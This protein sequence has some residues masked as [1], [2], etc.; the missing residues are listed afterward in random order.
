MKSLHIYSSGSK[1]INATDFE[2]VERKGI[3]HPDTMCDAIAE[4]I[5][6]DYSL[7]TIEHYGAI[8][9][10]MVDKIAISGGK[11][12]VFFGGGEM[13]KTVRVFL[14]CRFTSTFGDETI[15]YY[16]IA[17]NAIKKVFN[18]IM[19]LLDFD[20]YVE[21]IDNTHFSQGPGVVYDKDGTTRNERQFFFEVPKEDF[22]QFHNNGLRSND[23]STAVTYAP[24][25]DMENIVLSTEKMLNSKE[26]K[27]EHPYVG[28]DIKIMGRRLGKEI[29][30]TLCIPFISAFTDSYD[31]YVEKLELLKVIIINSVKA[32]FPDYEVSV[33]LNTRDNHEK[34][35]YYITLTGSAVECGD[36]GAV[37]RGN[38]YNGI[39]PFTRRMSMEASCGKN[40]VYHVGKIYTAVGSLIANNIFESLGIENNIY[41]TSQIGHSL[42]N[43][44]SF[45]IETPT[46]APTEQEK[47]AIEAIVMKHL[48][49]I[50]ETTQKI[51]K[52]QIKLY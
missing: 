2:V 1:P 48:D 22:I 3:G 6:S 52:G 51:I 21:V 50:E 36:E 20:K 12:R 42:S 14:N 25:S 28:T 45:A 29:S 24:L 32:Q 23:T 41:I 11:S 8:L 38:R 33:A 35:D 47:L 37:G 9:R 5:S 44:W 46:N 31:F 19:P 7:Y 18:E 13:L 26:F 39:I 15:P 17:R 40:P 10:H 27:K 16:D 30:L 43:P 34:S 49:A 4:Q